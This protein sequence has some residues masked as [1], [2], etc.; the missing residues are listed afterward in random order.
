MLQ[1]ILQ[2]RSLPIR[3]DDEVMVT[4]GTN[5]DREGKVM[6][7]N[8]RKFRISIERI[9]KDKSNGQPSTVWIHPSKVVLTQLKMDRYRRSLIERKCRR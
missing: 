9:T 8:L 2:V 7:V 3:R 5:H 4:R 1:N 6:Q